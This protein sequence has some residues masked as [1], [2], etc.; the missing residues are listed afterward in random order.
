MFFMKEEVDEMQMPPF[1]HLEKGLC[2]AETTLMLYGTEAGGRRGIA[3]GG[4]GG[5][6]ETPA[7]TGCG[8]EIDPVGGEVAKGLHKCSATS[9]LM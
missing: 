3:E 7:G 8:R 1:P 2:G 6:E 9:A 4:S 5:T